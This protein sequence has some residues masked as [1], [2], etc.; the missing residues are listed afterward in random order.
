MVCNYRLSGK[1][2]ELGP[3]E[4]KN[5]DPLYEKR[6]EAPK[7]IEAIRACENKGNVDL[8][9][10]CAIQVKNDVADEAIKALVRMHSIEKLAV[11]AMSPHQRLSIKA[12]DELDIMAKRNVSQDMKNEA[13]KA[14]DAV[15]TG[16]EMF[17][18]RIMAEK[19]L[20]HLGARKEDETPSCIDAL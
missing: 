2:R 20:V 5:F 7:T 18:N 16:A 4:G 6:M 13:I 15:A 17:E 10:I 8:I 3:N 12:L 19:M 14:I 1:K 9:A 11:I